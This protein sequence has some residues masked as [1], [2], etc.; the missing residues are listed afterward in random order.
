MGPCIL[1][2]LP[3]ASEPALRRHAV[4]QQPTPPAEG[5]WPA[6]PKA[7][8]ATGRNSAYGQTRSARRKRIPTSPGTNII[9]PTRRTQAVT[10]ACLSMANSRDWPAEHFNEAAA[11]M[12]HHLGGDQVDHLCSPFDL[13]SDHADRMFCRAA[14]QR[15]L[16]VGVA[17]G[18]RCRAAEVPGRRARVWDS[19]DQPAHRQDRRCRFR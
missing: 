6:Y 3:T 17:S 9:R 4:K 10:S 16:I 11:L 12:V 8:T 13:G 14:I 5:A 2:R 19:P 7:P 15:M 1:N 18:S